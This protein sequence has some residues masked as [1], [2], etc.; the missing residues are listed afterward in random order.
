MTRFDLM[1]ADLA[2][3]CFR[4]GGKVATTDGDTI[5]IRS[6]T[7]K[8]TVTTTGAAL[9]ALLALIGKPTEKVGR[10]KVRVANELLSELA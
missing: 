10:E 8:S 7:G 2:I 6:A 9:R 3:R 1:T 4:D 5:A